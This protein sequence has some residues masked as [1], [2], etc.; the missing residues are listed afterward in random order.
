MTRIRVFK[1]LKEIDAF[2]VTSEYRDLAELLGLAEW[3]PVV[4]IGRLFAMDNDFGEH[5]F[6][7]WDARDERDA[8]ASSYGFDA[9]NLLTIDPSRFKDG[10]DGPCHADEFRA[11][12]WRDVLRSLE[13]SLEVLFDKARR[14]NEAEQKRQVTDPLASTYIEDLEGRIDALKRKFASRGPQGAPSA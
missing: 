8:I 13:L 6:D 10:K 1:Y 7:N 11:L 3:N 14:V 9:E 5:W 2:E 4:W 12:F